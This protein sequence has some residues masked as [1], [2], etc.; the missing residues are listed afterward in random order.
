MTQ[1]KT[2]NIVKFNPEN[3]G[4]YDHCVHSFESSEDKE[5]HVSFEQ[6]CYI[7]ETRS[8]FVE[9]NEV[10]RMLRGSSRIPLDVYRYVFPFSSFDYVQEEVVTSSEED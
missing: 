1:V 3:P 7:V 8:N 9:P 10:Q 2:I 5:V 4:T 6:N